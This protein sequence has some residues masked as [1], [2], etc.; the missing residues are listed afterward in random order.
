LVRKE[1]EEEGE[2]LDSKFY[3]ACRM[4]SDGSCKIPCYSEDNGC[5]LTVV[6]I[7]LAKN[8][9]AKDDP[10][11]LFKLNS[12]MWHGLYQESKI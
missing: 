8:L 9:D 11:V 2:W 12:I 1:N 3:L 7:F 10:P 6:K 4:M 5:N